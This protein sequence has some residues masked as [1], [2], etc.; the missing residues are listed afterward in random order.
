M[1]SC[2]FQHAIGFRGREKLLLH[3]QTDDGDDAFLQKDGHLADEGPHYMSRQTGSC[4]PP[5]R[6]R[7]MRFLFL[8]G[9]HH[10]QLYLSLF[11]SRLLFM[12]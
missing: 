5:S 12:H 6:D 4:Q 3:V 1:V 2:H 10:C 11:W 7:P 8:V 9:T